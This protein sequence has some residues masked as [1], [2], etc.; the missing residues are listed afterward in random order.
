MSLR[1]KIIRIGTKTLLILAYISS[2]LL[3]VSAISCFFAEELKEHLPLQV[4]SVF[5]L[6]MFYIYSKYLEKKYK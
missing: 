6:W 2:F 3:L 1:G 4:I 5:F